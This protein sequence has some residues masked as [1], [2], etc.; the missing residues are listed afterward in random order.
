MTPR[1]ER[2]LII[3]PGA[4]GDLICLLPAIRVISRQHP[5]ADIELMARTELAAFAVGRMGVARAYS[6]DR[7]E[8]SLLFSPDPDAPR[9][10]RPFFAQ[11]AAVHCFFGAGVARLRQVLAEACGGAVRF[12]PFRPPGEGH[13]SEAYLNSVGGGVPADATGLS[14]R[15]GDMIRAARALRAKGLA[16]RGRILLFPGSG[17]PSK[18]W[19]AQSFAALGR[20][21]GPERILAVLGPAEAFLA[22]HF[23]DFAILK[24]PPLECLAGL[25]RLAAFFVGNDSGVSHLA[26]AAGCKGVVIFGPTDA[27]RWRPG[28]AQITVCNYQPLEEL[29]WQTVARLVQERLR[30]CGQRGASLLKSTRA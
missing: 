28:Y 26:A 25:A 16:P 24:Q 9:R 18:N 11:F 22:P 4:L 19:P 29:R 6:I 27:A 17:N 3:F 7:S 13:I 20:A 5:G 10:A 30:V 23:A 2:I 21:L 14:L 1:N 15:P 8:V 12:Y